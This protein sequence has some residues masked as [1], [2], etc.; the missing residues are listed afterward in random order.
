MR[1]QGLLEAEK[2]RRAYQESRAHVCEYFV[3]PIFKQFELLLVFQIEH[4]VEFGNK[5]NAE[6]VT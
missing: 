6:G 3:R 4:A 5:S 2:S 1:D